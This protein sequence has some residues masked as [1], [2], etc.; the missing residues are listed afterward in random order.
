VDIRVAG[1]VKEFGGTAALRGVSLD[2]RAGE[3]IAL[4]GPSGSGKTTL[5]RVIAGLEV[6]E[7]GQVFFAGEDATDLAVQKRQVGFV[8]QHYALFR[9][10]TVADNIAYGLRARR[11]RRPSAREIARRVGDLLDL[12]QLAGYERRFPAQ[13]SGGQR[14]RVA[15]A[16][17][18]AVEP[19]VLLLDEPFGALDAKVRKDLRR[20]LRDIHEATGQTTVFV[21][22]DQDEALELADRVAVLN[23]GRL[24]Q[25]GTPDEIQDAPASPFVMTFLGDAA[26]VAARAEDGVAVVGGRRTRIAVPSWAEGEVVL[27]CR[28]WDIR[29]VARGEADV[30]GT[31]RAVRR[32]GGTR[33]VEVDLPSGARLEVEAAAS[34]AFRPGEPA[35]LKIERA[36]VFRA[37][38]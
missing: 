15:L 8:F 10:L 35:G 7:R 1:I 26:Q 17:A 12:V 25:V 16:R 24:E 30:V 27:F 18:L 13:L 9:H 20:W 31:I 28:P 14:Q 38:S 37:K 22:H 23:H 2:V 6:P 33:R 4:L 3:L 29:I 5:L 11:E 36:S 21:T 19:R 32:V 34:G